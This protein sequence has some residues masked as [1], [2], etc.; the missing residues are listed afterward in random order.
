MKPTTLFAAAMLFFLS[1]AALAQD[2]SEPD[3]LYRRRGAN[4]TAEAPGAKPNWMERISLGGNFGLSLG[5]PTYINLAPLVGYRV[6]DRLTPGGGVTYIYSRVRDIY[7]QSF[8]SSIYG[9]RV[10]VQ[11]AIIPRFA[12]I[13]EY[14]A[15]NVA[16]LNYNAAGEIVEARRWIGNPMV[17][18]TVLFPIG[19]KSNF[20]LTALYNLNFTTNQA[21]S[22]YNSPWV[23]RAG[24]ML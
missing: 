16:Y 3:S 18:A 23:I 8:S 9:G 19:R 2:Q 5:N 10:N 15:L 14:E 13:V 22:P 6:N 7:G 11:Y 20:G 24:F 1:F 17:G 21:Y 4:K 12:P